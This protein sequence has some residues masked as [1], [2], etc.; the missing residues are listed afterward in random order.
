M[1]KKTILLLSLALFALLFTG[2]CSQVFTSYTPVKKYKPLA[3]DAEVKYLVGKK[4]C[5]VVGKFIVSRGTE[6]WQVKVAKKFAR[7]RGANLVVLI[8]AV[9]T[10]IVTTNQHGATRTESWTDRTFKLCRK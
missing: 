5:S 9:T 1:R 10:T 2:A 4:K 6:D 7:K 8:R 3:E